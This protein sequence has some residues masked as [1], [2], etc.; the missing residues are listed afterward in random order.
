MLGFAVAVRSCRR[1]QQCTL[2]FI[3]RQAVPL[4]MASASTRCSRTCTVRT[5]CHSLLDVDGLWVPCG[6][7][8]KQATLLPLP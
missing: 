8:P 5:A 2:Q 1:P 3:T 6:L 4:C 7:P